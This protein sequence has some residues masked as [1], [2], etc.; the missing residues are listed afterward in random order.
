MTNGTE[1]PDPDALLRALDD[2]EGARSTER[3]HLKLFL[4]FAAGVGK[5]YRMLREAILLREN[6]KDVVAAYIET[7]GREE[8]EYLMLAVDALPR[9]KIIY[10]GIDLEEMDIDAVIARK[11]AFALVDELAHTNVHGL[12]HEKRYQDVEEILNA[13]I[14]VYSCMNVQHIESLNDTV[15]QITGVRVRETVPDRI[16]A[17]AD[18]IELIDIPVEEL[19]ERIKEGKVYIPEKA[20]IAAMEFFRKSNLL[21][22][23][24]LAL[25]VT[26]RRVDDDIAAYRERTGIAGVIPAGSRLLVCVSASP[27]SAQLI[28][29][30]Q[31]FAEGLDARWTAVYVETPGMIPKR[32]DSV[33]LNGNLAL[34]E[35]LGGEVM[36]LSGDR[37]A[38]EIV[39]FAKAKN[40]TLIVIGFSRRSA[41]ERMVRGSIIDEIV[42]K[43]DPIQVLVIPGGSGRPPEIKKQHERSSFPVRRIALALGVT[44][45]ATALAFPAQRIFALGLQDIVLIYLMPILVSSLFGGMI[46]GIAASVIAVLCY[47]FFFVPPIF[48]F[49]IADPHYLLTF[50]VLSAVG[51]AT[52]ILSDRIRRQKE[53][54]KR[55]E[56]VLASLYQFSKD[57]L[58]AENFSGLSNRITGLIADLF[59]GTAVLYIPHEGR[60]SAVSSSPLA[61]MGEQENSIAQWVFEHSEKAGFG[62]KTLSSSPWFYAPITLK[63]TLGVLCIRRPEPL[64]YEEDRLLAS[65]IHVAG[66]AI[67]N[68]YELII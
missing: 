42:R 60:V 66:M 52:S 17:M 45:A 25:R 12:R 37:P 7:H 4:G 38:D 6:G 63:G 62:T 67:A 23:R 15:F 46:A 27:S 64:T 29:T 57:L 59:S 65:F 13:G 31:Q 40:I 44:A 55:N 5:T 56:Q 14:D 68:F 33:Q 24:E 53:T 50:G 34:A 10:E 41:L 48:T 58:S 36:K 35:G 22:L 32:T 26:A 47:N 21:A 18:K 43:S 30:T 16:I 39:R 61:V 11:P 20:R 1:R 8:T 9:K 51:I 54:A 19:T 28:R 49:T 2:E 3:G